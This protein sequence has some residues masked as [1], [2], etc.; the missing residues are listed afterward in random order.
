M[1]M[2]RSA[3]ARIFRPA[4]SLVPSSRTTIGTVGG[5]LRKAS[6]TPL[7]TIAFVR[8]GHPVAL[9]VG[10][11][12]LGDELVIHGSTGSPWL[13]ELANGAAA[14]V[15]VTLLDGIVVARSGF[16]SSFQYRSAVLFGHFQPV[17]KDDKNGYLQQLTDAFIPGRAAELRAST[18]RELAATLVLRL[19]IGEDNWSLKV[20]DGWPEDDEA[21]IA[22]GVWAGAVPIVTTYGDPLRAPDCDEAIPVPESVR[23]MIR[24]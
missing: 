13:R 12:R 7:A 2:I 14:S 22:A 20:A 3:S 19:A 8:D 11:A 23:S 17:E 18:A 6:T 5:E 9:P 16:E 21:D 15:S 1:A 4:S 10:F 24:P